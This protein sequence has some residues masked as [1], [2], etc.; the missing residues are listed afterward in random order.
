[1]N[2]TWIWS[3]VVSAAMVMALAACGGVVD[4]A[5]PQAEAEAKLAAQATPLAEAAARSTPLV[6]DEGQAM[7][8][9]VG[10]PADAGARTRAGRYASADQAAALEAALATVPSASTSAAAMPPR[11][12]W[13]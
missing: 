13:R 11:P 8:V 1:M 6:D 4:V 7:P 3:P 12:T 9:S 5:A 2:G 10:P